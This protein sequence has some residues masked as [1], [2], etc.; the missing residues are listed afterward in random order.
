MGANPQQTLQA[1]REAEAYPGTSLILAYSHCIAHG[2]DMQL[3]LHQQDL[4]VACGYWP[5]FRYNPAMRDIGENPFR[6]DSPRPTLKFHDYA[7]NEIRYRSLAQA[8]PVE[9][10]ALAEAAQ[11]AIMEKYRTYEDMAGWAPTRFQPATVP[12]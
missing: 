1:F 7:Y 5:L 2:I 11:A 10:Q 6:L 3:G 8:R 12:A 4:A 9:A